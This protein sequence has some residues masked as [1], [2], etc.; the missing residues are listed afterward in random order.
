MDSDSA[1]ASLPLFVLRRR[2]WSPVPTAGG[3]P[4]ARRTAVVGANA[5]STGASSG[6]SRGKTPMW[7][8]RPKGGKVPEKWHFYPEGVS[9]RPASI[10]DL[11]RSSPKF[12][13]GLGRKNWKPRPLRIYV[14]GFRSYFISSVFIPQVSVAVQI[15]SSPPTTGKRNLPFNRQKP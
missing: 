1:T 12:Q 13:N 2:P 4:T 11:M 9:T 3:A 15:V 6:I 14:S 8:P 10:S 5:A 7:D